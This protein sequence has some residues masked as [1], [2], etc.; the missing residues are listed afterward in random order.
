KP[1][2]AKPTDEKPAEPKSENA[3]A[4]KP[5]TEKNDATPPADAAA[6]PTAKEPKF[7]PLSEVREQ[8]LTRLAQPIAEEARKKAVTEVTT[9]IEKY[10]KALRRYNDVKSVKKNADI[11]A[12]SDL[13]LVPLAA[14]YGFPISEVPLVDHY[15]V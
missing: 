11:Q 13:E 6:T 9:A 14:K 1:A 7:K 4:D 15:D 3:P 10:G 2:E 8:I 5:A 12:P